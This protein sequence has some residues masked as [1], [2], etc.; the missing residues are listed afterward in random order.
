M[1]NRVLAEPWSAVCLGLWLLHVVCTPPPAGSFP[2]L[3][4]FELG[5]TGNRRGFIK[6]GE[7]LSSHAWR[8]INLVKTY[9]GSREI[10]GAK[11]RLKDIFGIEFVASDWK[12][13][14]DAVMDAEEDAAVAEPAV[15]ALMPD[16]T[17]DSASPPTLPNPIANDR[18]LKEVESAFADRPLP[19]RRGATID[20]LLDPQ[21]V[22]EDFDSEFLRF[23]E[24]E[25]G[26]REILE[27]LKL[28][29]E[30]EQDEEDLQEPSNSQ[31]PSTMNIGGIDG[32][33]NASFEGAPTASQSVTSNPGP[34]VSSDGDMATW[35]M[36]WRSSRKEG[37]AAPVSTKHDPET[38]R[39]RAAEGWI[40]PPGLVGDEID[41]SRLLPP[42]AHQLDDFV[43]VA[44]RE[45]W[46]YVLYQTAADIARRTDPMIP[47]QKLR[48]FAIGCGAHG[49]M[50]MGVV[51]L[52]KG[53]STTPAPASRKQHDIGISDRT[54]NRLKE[55]VPPPVVKRYM[56]YLGPMVKRSSRIESSAAGGYIMCRSDVIRE[57]NAKI[58]ESE[59]ETEY[60][61][62]QPQEAIDGIRRLDPKVVPAAKSDS[63]AL[64]G[65]DCIGLSVW[66]QSGR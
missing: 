53:A 37:S 8:I 24:G 31:G 11:I 42:P 9:F 65:E 13:A 45:L 30:D 49:S 10:F 2:G 54:L 46:D 26:T 3:E 55:E 6:D 56:D 23:A 62:A 21:I 5:A 61:E 12:S 29:D 32:P 39:I 47:A 7:N 50:V 4:V 44:N 36:R 43:I 20:E 60:C 19:P 52:F 34:T 17:K 1:R 25:E 28:R 14:L 59:P 40:S 51:D 35:A 38:A 41:I 64:W 22:Q 57:I 66:I 15:R 18:R 16:F 63:R 33:P 58:F 27:Y 48:D